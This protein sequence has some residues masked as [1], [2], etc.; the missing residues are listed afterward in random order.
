MEVRSGLEVAGSRS[1]FIESDETGGVTQQVSELLQFTFPVF[2]VAVM[3]L[4]Y[5]SRFPGDT[6]I[7]L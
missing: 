4:G 2:T 7:A 1:K 3:V 5:M 6:E